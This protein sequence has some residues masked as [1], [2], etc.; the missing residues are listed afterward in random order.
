M[1]KKEAIERIKETYPDLKIDSIVEEKDKFY[2]QLFRNNN[3]ILFGGI[4][5][6]DKTSGKVSEVNPMRIKGLVPKLMK[7]ENQYI[8]DRVWKKK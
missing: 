4:K 2:F 7:K 1:D 3:E 8:I 6:V 5:S